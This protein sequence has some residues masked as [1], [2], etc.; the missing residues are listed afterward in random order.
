MK[1]C[2][3]TVCSKYI[4]NWYP[5]S[6]GILDIDFSGRSCPQSKTNLVAMLSYPKR[7]TASYNKLS[8]FY[9]AKCAKGIPNTLS[10]IFLS[11]YTVNPSL[12]QKW[13]QFPFVTRFPVQLWAI[14]WA[15]IDVND[16]SPA[17][18]VGVT[19]V[20]VGFSIPP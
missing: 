11:T 15:I 16:L 3:P 12:I 18:R 20:S 5:F 4:K 9:A 8:P 7:F 13:F 14:S 1:L 2:S 17:T 10:W 6:Y 19:K